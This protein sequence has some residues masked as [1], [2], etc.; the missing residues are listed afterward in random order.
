MGCGTSAARTTKSVSTEQSAGVLRGRQSDEAV[1][2]PQNSA[3]RSNPLPVENH[4]LIKLSSPTPITIVHFNDVYCVDARGSEP[5]GGAARFVTGVKQLSNK[6]PL[7]LFSGDCFSPSAM[8]NVTK[9]RHM[10]PVLNEVDVKAAVIGNHDFDFGVDNL[11]EL[12]ESTTAVWLLSN[13]T[14]RTTGKPLAGQKHTIIEWEGHKVG[15]MGLI[16]QEWLVTLATISTDDVT[17]TGFVEQAKQTAEQLR[18]EGADIVIALTHMRMPNDV[19]LAEGTQGVIDLVLGGHDHS[20][21]TKQVGD[22]FVCKSG[23]DFREFTE[24]TVNFDNGKLNVDTCKHQITSDIPE[25]EVVKAALKK[26][27]GKITI[28]SWYFHVYQSLSY[29]IK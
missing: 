21:E 15:L 28:V 10:V 2:P 9:G 23:T 8:S 27:Q 6:R 1:G 13:V 16:E 20:Y 14:D 29:Q 18:K 17:F 7:V 22:V 25:D 12:I 26:F 5:I 3:G 11:C 19:L 24:I 4:E